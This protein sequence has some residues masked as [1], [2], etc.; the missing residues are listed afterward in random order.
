MCGGFRI[1]Q[2]G[3]AIFVGEVAIGP[4]RPKPVAGIGDRFTEQITP[5]EPAQAAM[6]PAE[7]GDHA[8]HRHRHRPGARNAGGIALRRRHARRW[9]GTVEHDRAAARLVEDMIKRVAAEPRHHRLDDREH[10]PGRDRGVDRVAAGAQCQEA[11]LG[12]QRMVRRHRAAPPD[13]QWPPGPQL[14]THI[15]SPRQLAPAYYRRNQPEGA[16]AANYRGIVRE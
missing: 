3:R 11:G 7:G 14:L 15:H 4:R 16:W 9:A 13:D 8:R 5:G 10:E 2:Q 12:R 1:D 6:H